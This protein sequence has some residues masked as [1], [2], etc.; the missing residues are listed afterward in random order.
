M[1]PVETASHCV[2]NDGCDIVN[3]GVHSQSPI[4]GFHLAKHYLFCRYAPSIMDSLK[5]WEWPGDEARYC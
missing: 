3:S 2:F 1:V 5:T 4:H